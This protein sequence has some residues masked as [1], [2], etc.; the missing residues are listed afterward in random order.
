MM[1]NMT[2]L[3]MT[4]RAS[5]IQKTREKVISLSGKSP[6]AT[7]VDIRDWIVGLLPENDMNAIMTAMWDKHLYRQDVDKMIEHFD[8][9]SLQQIV[10]AMWSV[11][12]RETG[13]EENFFSRQYCDLIALRRRG[14]YKDSSVQQPLSATAQSSH[15]EG[16]VPIV[17]VRS[18][19]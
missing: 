6:R 2:T 12:E 9:H 7:D 8:D 5:E 10:L 17:R 16:I 13:E 11:L 4:D 18:V 14:T 1:V 15:T 3:A 19:T